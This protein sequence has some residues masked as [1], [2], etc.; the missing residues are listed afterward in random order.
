ME[1]WGWDHR[2]AGFDQGAGANDSKSVLAAGW[3]IAGV[4]NGTAVLP[5]ECAPSPVELSE[6][7]GSLT[8]TNSV[9]RRIDPLWNGPRP[10][11]KTSLALAFASIVP[12]VQTSWPLVRS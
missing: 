2:P 12:E 11:T 9:P 1:D 6:V 4:V 3:R 10:K 7:S 5:P 8:P